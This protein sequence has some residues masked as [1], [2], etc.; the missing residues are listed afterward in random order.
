MGKKIVILGTANTKGEQL[1]FLKEKITARGHEAV[2]ALR[3]VG[4][5]EARRPECLGHRRQRP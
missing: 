5:R 1:R 2:L 4:G 3:L